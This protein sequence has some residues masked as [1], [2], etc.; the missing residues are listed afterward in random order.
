MADF[1]LWAAACETALWPPGTRAYEANRRAA[2]ECIIDADPF[3]AC[4]REIM[5]ERSSW[6]GSAA[7]LLRAGADR[8][9]GGISRDSTGWPK[10]PRA[11]AGRLR[12]AQT[13][14]RV[15]GIDITFSRE[16]RAGSRIIRMHALSNIPSA[17]SAPSATLGPASGHPP[18]PSPPDICED[19]RRPDLVGFWPVAQVPIATTDDADGADAN[20][21]LRGGTAADCGRDLCERPPEAM[22]GSS[23]W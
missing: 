22:P 9:G 23:G 17:P 18:P 19:N 10:N 2:I 14:L 6:T 7:D 13:F 8:S 5:T 12:R 4:V 15:L 1:A 21:A 11:L 20:A 3:A 16:G